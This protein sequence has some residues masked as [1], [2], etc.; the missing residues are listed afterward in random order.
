M[1]LSVLIN[2]FAFVFCGYFAFRGWQNRHP[3]SIVIVNV[4][5][6]AVNLLLVLVYYMVKG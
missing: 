1:N 2:I 4:L 3:R 5:F 6:S